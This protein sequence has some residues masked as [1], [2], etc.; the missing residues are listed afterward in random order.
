M[1]VSE[2]VEKLEKRA[3]AQRREWPSYVSFKTRAELDA[4]SGPPV[5][6]YIGVS[7]DDWPG[8][9]ATNE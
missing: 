7:P 9:A 8:K 6:G 3:N 2:R 4:Y 1:N 5:K